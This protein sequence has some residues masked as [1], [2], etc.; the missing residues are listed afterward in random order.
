M[1][2]TSFTG[3]YDDVNG[4]PP[5]PNQHGQS[6]AVYLAGH[7]YIGKHH[8]DAGVLHHFIEGITRIGGLEDVKAKVRQLIN[9]SKSD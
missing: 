7:V 3:S 4:R 8:L 6:Q 5:S 1:L 9:D 2:E